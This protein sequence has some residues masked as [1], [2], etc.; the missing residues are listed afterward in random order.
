MPCPDATTDFGEMCR[1]CCGRAATGSYPTAAMA[2][3]RRRDRRARRGRRPGRRRRRGRCRRRC[4]GRRGATRSAEHR[5]APSGE[6]GNRDDR[7]GEDASGADECEPRAGP[8]PVS[9]RHHHREEATSRGRPSPHGWAVLWPLSPHVVPEGPTRAV[10]ASRRQGT[11]ESAMLVGLDPSTAR[12]RGQYRSARPWP[13]L[14]IDDVVSSDVAATH[15]DRG[16][17]R[18]HRGRCIINIRGASRSSA[19]PVPRRSVRQPARCC[20]I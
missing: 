4:V 19:R 18:P 2:H 9:R 15:R 7:D 14:V 11:V 5:A 20:A 1:R 6:A 10:A 13:H 3:G 17:P 16:Q 12:M 8:S